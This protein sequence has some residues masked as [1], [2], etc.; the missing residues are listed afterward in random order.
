V[1]RRDRR[2]SFIRYL[3]HVPRNF[4]F[5]VNQVRN[6]LMAACSGGAPAAAPYCLACSRPPASGSSSDCCIRFDADQQHVL[7]TQ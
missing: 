4:V 2:E 1:T 5:A 7:S 3:Y 6:E